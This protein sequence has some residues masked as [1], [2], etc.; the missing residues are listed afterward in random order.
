LVLGLL[1]LSAATFAI[2]DATLRSTLIGG[3]TASAGGAIAYYFSS[4]SADQARQD[5]VAAA[6]GKE[7]V[8]DL[9]GKTVDQAKNIL[10]GTTLRLSQDNAPADSTAPIMTQ[11][12]PAD[13]DTVKGSTIKVTYATK[14]VKVPAI[15]SLTAAQGAA[16]LTKVGLKLSG[17]T[18]A[19]NETATIATQDPPVDSEQWEGTEITVTYG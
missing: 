8:P 16:A 14:K 9:T 11:L 18:P 7:H 19:P 5:L 1:V 3:L 6:F 2:D 15:I 10:G 13:T 17:S 12:P 4:K